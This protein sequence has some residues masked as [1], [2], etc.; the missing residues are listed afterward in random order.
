M[1]FSGNAMGTTTKIG[2]KHKLAHA[3]WSISGFCIWEILDYKVLSHP[4]C[5]PLANSK[6]PLVLN[7]HE[8]EHEN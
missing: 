2:G 7:V 8:S 1:P 4:K 5:V 6:T 3:I